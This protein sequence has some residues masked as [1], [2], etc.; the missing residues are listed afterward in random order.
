[1]SELP[2]NLNQENDPWWAKHRDKA[3]LLMTVVMFLMLVGLLPSPTSRSIDSLA[4]DH[5]EH[6]SVLR[7]MCVHQAV[8]TKEA[9]ECMTNKVTDLD[10]DKASK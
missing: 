7:V 9:V 8:S 4:D 5:K 3:F 2:I 6:S 1:M 10:K